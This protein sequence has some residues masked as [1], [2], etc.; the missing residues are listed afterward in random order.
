MDS[1][2]IILVEFVRLKDQASGM[3]IIRYGAIGTIFG[4]IASLIGIQFLADKS[5]SINEKD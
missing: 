1:L 5:V 3:F 2:L 4:F